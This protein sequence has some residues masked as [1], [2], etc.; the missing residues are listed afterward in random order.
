LVAAVRRL[1]RRNDEDAE[2]RRG[3]ASL[4]ETLRKLEGRRAAAKSGERESRGAR[5]ALLAEAGVA[6]EDEFRRRHDI[7]RRRTACRQAAAQCEK[8]LVARLGMG[9]QAEAWRS[10]LATGAV[11]LWGQKLRVLD[12]EL[13]DL[14]A[15]RER[16]IAACARAEAE[17]L[18]IE[19]SSDLAVKEADIAACK[20][21][22]AWALRQFRVLALARG[23]VEQTL[24]GYTAT[25]QPKVL[26]DAS[27]F[28][29]AVTNGIY[30][31]VVQDE[32]GENLVVVNRVEERKRPEELSRGTAE[33][34]YLCLRLGLAMEF[35]RRAVP[36][37]LVMD[38]VLVNFDPERAHLVAQLLRDLAEHPEAPN[39]VLVFTCHPE[40][41]AAVQAAS[42]ACTVIE[43]E[44]FGIPKLQAAGAE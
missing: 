7:F 37:P 9:E 42:P 4:G 21:E 24:K 22:L 13:T 19:A 29:A 41:L 44:R 2:H 28:L 31:K 38:D 1:R 3:L 14:D 43:L 8:Q 16:V 35:S 40:T 5:D 27:G 36:V 30:V 18:Q 33:L 20:E 25:R 34:L 17:R 15:E 26:A 39:Q 12:S 32:E 23:L 6:T 11:A 10:E